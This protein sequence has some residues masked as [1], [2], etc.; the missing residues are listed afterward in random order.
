MSSA[1]EI[2]AILA[3]AAAQTG[4][5]SKQNMRSQNQSDMVLWPEIKR[6]IED[7]I[8]NA[9]RSLQK[10]IGPSEMGTDCLH[11]LAA[12]LAGWQQA[13]S[14][15]SWLPA[16]GTSVHAQ[17]EK[18]FTR[19]NGT[20]LDIP[21]DRV[22]WK[23]EYRVEVGSINGTPITGSIDLWDRQTQST[24]DWKV[25]G[26]TTLRNVKANGPSQ[27]YQVQASLYAIGLENEGETVK[28][29]CIYFLPRNAVSLDA[30]FIWEAGFDRRP[31]E[32]AL[33]RANL[34]QVI[35]N[36]LEMECGVEVR[37]AWIRKL[38]RTSTH[39]FDCANYPDY[40]DID[41][42]ELQPELVEIP[43]KWRQATSLL[44]AAY[45]NLK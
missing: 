30:A 27:Q 8:N 7:D 20:N 26:S 25:V 40:T 24:V 5:S 28:H 9:P 42:G 16:I 21:N 2:S 38:P 3:T 44:D 17:M 12:K 29:S 18:L 45:P 35:L 23:T 32:W 41:Y 19:L 37:D 13:K 11:C 22:R 36:T 31:G 33:A 34:L 39:C 14:R 15:G 6:I 4:V 43:D 10:R 1:E